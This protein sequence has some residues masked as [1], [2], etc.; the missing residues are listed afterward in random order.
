ML[1]IFFLPPSF[2]VYVSVYGWYPT[3]FHILFQ[4]DPY[5]QE[6]YQYQCR[7]RFFSLPWTYNQLTFEVS[8]FLCSGVTVMVFYL[9]TQMGMKGLQAY[10]YYALKAWS[11]PWLP[12][13]CH[14]CILRS[15]P[16][17]SR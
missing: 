17:A 10:E 12:G 8:G 3:P 16:V 1:D 2:R 6:S 9:L 14:D 4:K 5:R 15:S 7:G 11:L 13:L